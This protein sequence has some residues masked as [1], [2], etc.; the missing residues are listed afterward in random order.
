VTARLAQCV[1]QHREGHGS[2]SCVDG[3]RRLVGA[4]QGETIE[5]CIAPEKRVK[6]PVGMISFKGCSA[7]SKEQLDLGSSPD[8][9]NGCFLARI[10]RKELTC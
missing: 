3:L 6:R 2:D 8:D 5:D 9:G 4:E 7:R 10:G 1:I